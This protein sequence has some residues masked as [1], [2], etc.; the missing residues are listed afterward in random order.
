VAP[1]S[2]PARSSDS[3]EGGA[4]KAK[5]PTPVRAGLDSRETVDAAG[6]VAG[7]ELEVELDGEPWVVTVRGRALSDGGAH[8]LLVGFH[9]RGVDEPEREGMAV[10]RELEDLSPDEL[11]AAWGR[12]RPVPE[13]YEAAP[14]FPG[15]RRDR[16]RRAR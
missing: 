14:F 6:A 2:P 11:L 3:G 5:R 1:R 13:P 15:T 16:N 8:L 10:G 12:S 7:S 4:A 9:P